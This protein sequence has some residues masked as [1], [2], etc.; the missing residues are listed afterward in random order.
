MLSQWI[1][2]LQSQVFRHGR[3]TKWVNQKL[4]SFR[5][6]NLEER[7]PQTKQAF[8]WTML[9]LC[10]QTIETTACKCKDTSSAISGKTCLFVLTVSWIWLKFQ[11]THQQTHWHWIGHCCR[12]KGHRVFTHGKLCQQRGTDPWLRTS[13]LRIC[14]N[15]IKVAEGW[16]LK[17]R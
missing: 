12:L 6:A 10:K 17:R 16:R 13:K 14:L 4:K 9:C 1:H 2:R 15:P 8:Q 11:S 5:N 3:E 7:F